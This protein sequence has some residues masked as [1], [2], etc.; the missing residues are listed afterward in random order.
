[1]GYT[2]AE[3]EALPPA[4]R[5]IAKEKAREVFF[6]AGADDVLD[7]LDQLPQWLAGQED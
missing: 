6:L 4:E 5:E 2:Q 1:M 7:T 3:Y